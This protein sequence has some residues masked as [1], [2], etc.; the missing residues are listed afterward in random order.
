MTD[1]IAFW[2]KIFSQNSDYSCVEFPNKESPQYQVLLDASKH[3]GDVNGKT[4]I[5]IGCGRGATS[6][7]FAQLGANVISIDYSPVAVKNLSNFCDQNGITN[8]TPVC[9]RAQEEVAKLK[10]DFVFGSMILHHIE[11]FPEFAEILSQAISTGGM[12]FFWENNARSKAMIWVRTNLVG[13]LWIPK[14]GDEEEFPLM[15]SEVDQLRKHFSVEI[16]YPELLMFRLMSQY[17][18]RGLC[19]WP[20]QKLDSILYHVPFIRKYSYRQYVILTK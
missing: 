10:A 15:V 2:N 1:S 20:F 11:P 7:Y 9:G 12:A 3:F 16:Q 17:L 6:L 14:Y 8:I 13:K 5:D 18:L 19:K 4:L